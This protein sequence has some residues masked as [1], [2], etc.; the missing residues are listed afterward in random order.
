MAGGIYYN[1]DVWDWG[2]KLAQGGLAGMAMVKGAQEI[3]SNKRKMDMEKRIDAANTEIADLY[4]E[5]QGKMQGVPKIEAIPENANEGIISAAKSPALAEQSVQGGTE[6]ATGLAQ[7]A[8]L[9]DVEGNKAKREAAIQQRTDIAAELAKKRH[10][11][12]I[13]HQLPELADRLKTQHI[14]EAAA[15]S[16]NVSKKAGLSFLQKGPLADYFEGVT[17]D[18]IQLKDRMVKIEHLGPNKDGAGMFDLKTKQFEWVSQP[19]AKEEKEET[20][21]STEWGYGQ[22]K[23][24]SG[25]DKGKIVKVPTAPREGRGA[26]DEAKKEWSKGDVRQEYNNLNTY[27][28]KVETDLSKRIENEGESEGITVQLEKVR[29]IRQG[30]M[31]Y[32]SDDEWSVSDANSSERG[33]YPRN[34]QKISD[35]LAGF[36]VEQKKDITKEKPTVGKKNRPDLNSYYT[37]G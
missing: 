3:Q 31:K 4:K 24:L 23:I 7:A 8:Q 27:L 26:K 10:D 5:A 25:P 36:G 14:A 32:R 15:L 30:L 9:K 16:K 13:K 33:K 34:L 21:K 29:N 18:D 1:P 35:Y 6:E 20:E 12:Y 17:E 11:I 2:G 22:R 37:G 19:S 28:N